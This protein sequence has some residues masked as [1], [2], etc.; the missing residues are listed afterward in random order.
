V[1][2]VINTGIHPRAC[3]CMALS[4]MLQ[5][6]L[7]SILRQASIIGHPSPPVHLPQHVPYID[8]PSTY[9]S[10]ALHALRSLRQKKEFASESFTS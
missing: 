2:F 9:G 6:A 3:E 7:G 1:L 4:A 10:I 8:D 5:K